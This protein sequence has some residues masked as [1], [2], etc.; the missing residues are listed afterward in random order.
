MFY[1]A[2]NTEDLN[3]G[4]SISGNSERLLRRS[5]KGSQKI[6]EFLQQSS[7]SWGIKR[8]V[9]I[10]EHQIAWVKELSAFRFRERCKSLGSLKSF[11]WHAPLLS[12]A[13]ILCFHILSFFTVHCW[14][15]LQFDGCYG[16]GILCFLPELPQPSLSGRLSCDG[17]VAAHIL[18][19]LMCQAAFFHRWY[20]E[21]NE[22]IHSTFRDW[23]KVRTFRTEK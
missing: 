18:C 1:L 21:L 17:L 13:S 8:R 20:Q 22:G 4:R 11:L 9:L 23:T 5:K 10:K 3:L 6:Q 2:H 15:W 7:G 16:A 12:G 19:W 14:E